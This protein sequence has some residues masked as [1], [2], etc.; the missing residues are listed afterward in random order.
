MLPSEDRATLWPNVTYPV[1]SA[2]VSL[3]PCCVQVEPERANTQDRTEEAVVVVAAD[4]RQVAVV[5]ER[6][7]DAELALSGLARAGE[8]GAL[9]RPGG[10]RAGEHP[11]RTGCTFVVVPADQRGV[12]VGGQGDAPSEV[13]MGVAPP[14]V[15]LEPCCVQV[16]PERV[17]TQTAPA[18]VLSPSA[19]D[20]RRIAV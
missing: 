16:E 4:E 7:A 9:L 12:A 5:R 10:A 3:E 11:S 2:P 6:H 14:P 15:S 18:K 13:A 8:L 20:Q 17:N 19:A 1:A